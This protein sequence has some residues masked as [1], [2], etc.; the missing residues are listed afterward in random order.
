MGTFIIHRTEYGVTV[1]PW[2]DA[3]PSDRKSHRRTG[4]G[5]TVTAPSEA[6]L[7]QT[8]RHYF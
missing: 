1:T 7:R 8:L 5:F 2:D 6:K 3:T 4:R